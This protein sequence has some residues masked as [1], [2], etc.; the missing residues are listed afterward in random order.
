MATIITAQ[1]DQSRLPYPT[2]FRG[3]VALAMT[4]DGE[5]RVISIAGKHWRSVPRSVHTP[6][7]ALIERVAELGQRIAAVIDRVM[8][9]CLERLSPAVSTLWLPNKRLKFLH[10]HCDLPHS[11]RAMTATIRTAVRVDSA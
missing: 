11:R 1:W 4:I 7:G 8:T 5:R 3:G 9:R 6:A 2:L 10:A